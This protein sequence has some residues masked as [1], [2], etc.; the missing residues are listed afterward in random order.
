M[1]Q[2]IKKLQNQQH[3]HKGHTSKNFI[4]D[5]KAVEVNNKFTS[6][7]QKDLRNTLN[8]CKQIV[9]TENKWRYTNLNPDT[10]SL[11]G[12]VKVHKKDLPIRPIVNY[13]NAPSYKLAKMFTEK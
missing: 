5:N 9:G 1:A 4:A 8:N 13:R 10:P 7:F 12:L 6:K 2:N 3:L 11:R